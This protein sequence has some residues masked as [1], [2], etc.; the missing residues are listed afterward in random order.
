[1][2]DPDGGSYFGTAEEVTEID[3]ILVDVPAATEGCEDTFNGT[4]VEYHK[5]AKYFT[6]YRDRIMLSMNIRYMTPDGDYWR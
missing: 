1:M 4:P 3:K 5:L 2:P 6:F